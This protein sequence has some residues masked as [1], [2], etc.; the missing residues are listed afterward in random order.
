MWISILLLQLDVR[1]QTSLLQEYPQ[2]RLAVAALEG[3]AWLWLSLRRALWVSQ[4][5]L[6]QMLVAL[7]A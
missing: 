4:G 3:W 1:M 6:P 2:R 5:R 7:V